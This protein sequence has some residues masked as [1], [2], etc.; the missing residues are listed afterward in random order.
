MAFVTF[1]FFQVFNLLNVRH[2]TR[3]IF[4]RETL[5]NRSAF[6]ASAGDH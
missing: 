1:V 2:Y 6:I 4:S 3:S 5:H